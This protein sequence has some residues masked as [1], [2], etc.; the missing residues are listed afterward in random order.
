MTRKKL[1][2]AAGI[3]H[4]FNEWRFLDRFAVAKEHGF[5]AV[6]L[7]IPYNLPA[8]RL[9][10]VRSEADIEVALF[11]APVGN[12]MEGGEGLAAVPGKQREF[13]ESIEQALEY[14]EALEATQIQFLAGR[15]FG[16]DGE[17]AKRERYL[18]TLVENV[19]L[20]LEAF[21]PTGTRLVFEPI[22]TR[23]FDDYLLNRPEHLWELMARVGGDELGAVFDT[24]HLSLMGIDPVHEMCESGGRYCHIQLAD[25]PERSQPGSGE[26]DFPALYRAIRDS[27]YRGLIGAE[28][29]P[30]EDTRGSLGW[31]SEADRIINQDS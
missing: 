30:V 9:A 17:P 12:F 19:S 16:Q 5:A 1:K 29:H 13:G 18:A 11:T 25:T 2:F 24:Q 4:L 15:C 20:A 28:Y 14:A 31:M 7:T 10:Q 6:E 21:R 23:D 8:E 3:W 22:N 27:D 26:I